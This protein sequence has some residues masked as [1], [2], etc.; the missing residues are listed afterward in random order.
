M[1]VISS[2]WMLEV[3]YSKSSYQDSKLLLLVLDSSLSP[4][5]SPTLTML[6]N[7]LVSE[8][9]R[10]RTH[11]DINDAGLGIGDIPEGLEEAEHVRS[12]EAATVYKFGEEYRPCK[13]NK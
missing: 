11:Q 2:V 8:S 3:L 5:P 10:R 6:L 13:L 9:I 4:Q 12:K 1:N 7:G